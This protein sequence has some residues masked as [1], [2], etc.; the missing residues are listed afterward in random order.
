MSEAWGGR[1]SDK[2]L[3]EDCGFLNNLVPGDL[4]LADRGFTVHEEVWFRQVELNIPAFTKGKNQLDPLDVEKT[5]KIANV[6]P[7]SRGKCHW[8]PQTEVYN[9]SK[10]TPYRLS[11]MQ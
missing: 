11:H 1:T 7:H 9:S 8:H 2:F 10:H 6:S 5:R 4:V 3:T